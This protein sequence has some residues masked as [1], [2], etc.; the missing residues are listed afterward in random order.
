MNGCR[1]LSE[2]APSTK[3]PI[4]VGWILDARLE[5]LDRDAVVAA[6]RAV[7]D[8]LAADFPRFAWSL[9]VLEQELIQAP[10]EEPVTLLEAAARELSIHH[11]DFAIVATASDLRSHF[12]PTAVAVP[13]RP[14]GVAV[15]S[16]FRIDPRA[17]RKDASEEERSD[18]LRRRLFRCGMY[19]VGR[20]GG[21]PR[22]SDPASHMTPDDASV[23]PELVPSAARVPRGFDAAQRAKL[24]AELERV[25][26]RRIEEEPGSER[27][28]ALRFHARAAWRNRREILAQL[29]DN[30]S[31][32]F[33]FRMGRL[34]TA[35]LSALAILSATSESWELAAHLGTPATVLA[36]LVAIV[37]TS[38]YVLLRQ[39]LLA[40]HVAPRLT[41]QIVV[42]RVSTIL[43][44][45]M[46]VAFTFC[47]LVAI[48]LTLTGLLFSTEVLARWAARPGEE[49]GWGER[50]S[51]AAFASSLAVLV[52]SLGASFEGESY[53]RHVAFVDEEI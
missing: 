1:A 45:L 14:L 2:L 49:L 33:P 18:A 37:A 41:E 10:V 4:E 15:L 34:T 11:W 50:A 16:T 30:R 38:A 28:G 36:P 21:L 42:A 24:E 17:R 22:T 35:A 51:L 43:F 48:A 40:L 6:S 53:V 12:L 23:K 27:A 44:V 25:A 7:A 8:A 29:A 31:W 46:G 9:P 47:V 13:S 3:P 39:R 20:L 52:G 26:D 19:L 32:E 5:E